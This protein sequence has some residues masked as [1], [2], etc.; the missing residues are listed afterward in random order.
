LNLPL[1]IIREEG[2]SSGVFDV[3]T[4]DRFVHQAEMNT[5]WTRSPKFL[6]PFHRWV[7]DVQLR[8]LI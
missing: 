6:E 8:S 5:D 7:G 4:S 3:G 2:V 1:L